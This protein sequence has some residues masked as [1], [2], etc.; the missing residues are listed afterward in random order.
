MKTIE[1]FLSEIE[2]LD[3]K[4]WVEG[5]Q[6]H[7]NAPKGTI[8]STLLTQIKE[9]K[10]EILQVLN[11][12]DVIQAV[13]RNQQLPLSFAQQRLWLVEQ[14]QPDSFTYNE[15]VA[16]HLLGY[17]NIE[18]LEKSINEIVR[19]H[20]I[21]R[22]TFTAIDG[23]PL[24]VITPSFNVKVLVVDFS[25]LPAIEREY[26]AQKFAQQEAELP[27]YLTKLPLIRVTVLQL[28]KQENILLL[29]VHHIVW[30]G[31]SIGVLIREL[32]TLYSAFYNGQH[33]PLPELTIQYADFAVWQRNWL[34]GKV[35]AEK[36]A[37]WQERVGNNLPVLQLPTVRPRT[38]VKTN[39]GA[40]QSFVI[41]S[42]LAEAIQALSHQE[43]VSFFMTL[44]AAFQV[45]LLQYTKQE[46]IVIGT[47][48]ANRNRAE[49]ESLIGFFMN[50][51]VLRTDL[52]G[53]PSFRELLARVRQITLEAYA[54]PDL[55]FE[56]LVK[57]LQPERSLSN[58][59]PLFQVL[60]VLQ[61][62]PMPSLD[63][64][65]LTLKEW[66]WRN[67][68]ARF[69]LAVFLTKTPEGITS[70]WRYNSELFT[71]SAVARMASHFETL[72]NS[73]VKQPNARI[74]S[75]EILT[76]SEKRQ[77]A[78]QNSKRK[79][80]NR[81]KF[82]KIAPT[83][84]NLSSTNL[85]TTTYLQEG[86]TFPLV[87][88]PLADDVDLVDWAKSNRELI[89]NELLKHG[90][91]LFRGFQTNT[92]TEFETFAGAVCPNLFGDYG[93]LPRTGEG[94]K[95]YGS[96]PYPADKAILFHNESSHLHC[97]PLKIWFFCVQPAQ[98]GG[99]TPI[100]D[101]RKAY[102]I[103]P[104]K[105]REKLAQK[106]FMYVRNYTNNLDVSWQDFFHTSDKS[107]V[108]D[109][110]RQ[111]GISFEWYG[112]DSLITRQVRPALA[113]HPK[114][115][116]SVFFN[117]IQLHHIAYL[118]VKTRESLLSLFDEKQLPRNV[119]Y[120]DGTLIEDDVIAEI[121][122]VYK[123]SQTSFTWLKGD[124]LM[125]DNM[126]C[127]H[128]RSPYIGKRKIVVA[129]GEMIHGNNVAKLKEEEGSIC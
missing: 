88:Q 121:N 62:T 31:W 61:N 72:L 118:D 15:P 47:D 66:F 21:L 102:Q 120:G 27:F 90:A 81:E 91:I 8:T 115:G 94:N 39:R 84:I 123:Q 96:T 37:Y 55:P 128:G 110:C 85:V 101:C 60:F 116:E 67:D 89:E 82:I 58:T 98:Q 79:A 69:E 36:L 126:L 10:A 2:R 49:T 97:W 80:F 32:S 65:G 45:L 51:L 127:A 73:I 1:Q 3:V 43:C 117:Q 11:Q 40:S 33:S 35:L 30:D 41:P 28:G 24:Q 92:V 16:L 86:N 13:P 18:V 12:D 46:D 75:L 103:L 114:T 129:M 93:D 34:Q 17:L 68:T 95:V 122:H 104:A 63:L 4:L 74:N 25:N 76:E 70:T 109:Y 99:E 42:H 100:I 64:P 20:E 57:A 19:R 38:E 52:S 125:L 112:D 14:L 5:E 107:V 9:R 108:E 48:I 124:I 111:A 29:T 77:Q 83:S 56:E 50:L 113:V 54:H 59:S 106:Q 22:T 23:Q 26:K 53:N 105:F 87:I 71:E 44:L 78:M 119:Y 7:Y 6:L